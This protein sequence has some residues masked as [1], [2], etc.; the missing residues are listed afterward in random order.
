[1][2][3]DEEIRAVYDEDIYRQ[4]VIVESKFGKAP[5]YDNF[6][7]FNFDDMSQGFGIEKIVCSE[8]RPKQKKWSS[9]HGKP[10]GEKS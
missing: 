1:M 3:T 6:N 8:Y 2:S 5:F 7:G 10:S 4:T 9:K